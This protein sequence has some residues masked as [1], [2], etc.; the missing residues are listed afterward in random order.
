[1]DAL[2]GDDGL[3]AWLCGEAGWWATVGP[4]GEPGAGVGEGATSDAGTSWREWAFGPPTPTSEAGALWSHITGCWTTFDA[5]AYW[6][7]PS[8]WPVVKYGS[9]IGTALFAGVLLPCSLVG[10]VVGRLVGVP[11]LQTTLLFMAP[12][13]KVSRIQATS[14]AKKKKKKRRRGRKRG[15]KKKNKGRAA[16]AKD[17]GGGTTALR[18]PLLFSS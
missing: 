7:S 3:L 13:S 4:P 1:M 6:V 2:C 10:E 16:G 15:E 18:E 17:G 12:L 8:L 14:A 9:I 5:V 11:S